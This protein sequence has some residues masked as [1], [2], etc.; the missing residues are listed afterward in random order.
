[1][2]AFRP[3]DC[4]LV[5]NQ[6]HEDN[7]KEANHGFTAEEMVSFWWAKMAEAG[8]TNRVNVL[9]RWLIPTCFEEKFDCDDQILLAWKGLSH[10]FPNNPSMV[11][12][13]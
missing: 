7:G 3:T 5:G 13:R 10:Y 9:G 8:N 2:V 6:T 11:R 4:S 1:M 12:K